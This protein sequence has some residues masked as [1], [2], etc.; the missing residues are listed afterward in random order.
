M[1]VEV[2]PQAETVEPGRQVALLL[3]RVTVEVDLA[4][5]GG[6]L[7]GRLIKAAKGK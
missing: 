7:A 5:L 4:V 6:M 3:Q 1:P 2:A